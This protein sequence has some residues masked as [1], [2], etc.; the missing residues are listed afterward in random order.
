MNIM[1]KMLL[2][3][4]LVGGLC[5]T[6]PVVQAQER[7]PEYLQA[8]KFTQEK[9]NTMLFS[10]VVDPHWF[11]KGNNFWFQYKTSEGTFWYVV[12]PSARSKKQLFDRDEMASQLT[13]IVKDP[14]E[15]RHLPIRNLKAQEDGR[16]FTFEVVSSQDAKPK[17]EDKEKKDKKG[18]TEKEVF[19]F[20]YDYPTRKLT[21]LKDKEKEPKKIRWGSISPDGKTVVYAKDLNLYRMSREDYEKAKKNEKDSTIVEIQLTKDGVM[22]VHHDYDLKR[23][24]GVNKKIADLTYR[25]L[26]RYRLMGTRERIPR[27]VEVLREVDGKVPLLVELKMETCNRKLCKKVAKALD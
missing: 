2:F 20:S 5:T 13:E 27:F 15:A 26:C 16:T 11:Q 23:T 9:L 25:E 19:Y 24:C 14:F 22:V 7:L 1:K 8:E 21:H 10:T 6:T 17:K 4:L 18:K 12:D 3:T